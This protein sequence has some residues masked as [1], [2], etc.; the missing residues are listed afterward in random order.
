MPAYA[1]GVFK[2]TFG[3]PTDTKLLAKCNHGRVQN[4]SETFYDR[5]WE[6][7]PQTGPLGAVISFNHGNISRMEVLEIWNIETG[8]NMERVVLTATDRQGVKVAQEAAKDRSK[9]EPIRRRNQ[10]K[11]WDER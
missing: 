11:K 3:D 8:L 7:V 1:T 9:G 10:K 5:V 6:R 4:Q 2:L